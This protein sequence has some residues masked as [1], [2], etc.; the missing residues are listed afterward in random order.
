MVDAYIKNTVLTITVKLLVEM[1][2]RFR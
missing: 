2:Y 1:L